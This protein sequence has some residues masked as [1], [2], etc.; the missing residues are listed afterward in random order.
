[1]KKLYPLPDED[2]FYI[3]LYLLNSES[4]LGEFVEDPS[5]YPNGMYSH[6]DFNDN[7]YF[8][9]GTL[10]VVKPDLDLDALV[11]FSVDAAMSYATLISSFAAFDNP[12][13][14]ADY[15]R[16]T[17]INSTKHLLSE[18]RSATEEDYD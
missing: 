8:K 2:K 14:Q 18:L 9:V 3:E 7:Q 15:C 6:N 13:D 12:N 16:S 17:I 5:T 11:G 10:F 4:Q 1:M